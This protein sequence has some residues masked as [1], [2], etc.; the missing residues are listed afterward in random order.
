MSRKCPHGPT[1]CR[2]TE[3]RL[4]V[5]DLKKQTPPVGGPCRLVITGTD[6]VIT[7]SHS[8]I[9]D[10]DVVDVSASVVAFCPP[11]SSVYFLFLLN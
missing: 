9:S 5:K 6:H 8:L 1:I 11:H 7:T 2:A 10:R 3:L 4:Q